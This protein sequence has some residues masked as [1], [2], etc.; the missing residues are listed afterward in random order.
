MKIKDTFKPVIPYIKKSIPKLAIGLFALIIVDLIQLWLP[1]IMQKMIDN[2]SLENFEKSDITK[3]SLI[4]IGLTLIM[5]IMRFFWRTTIIGNAWSLERNIRKDLHNHLMKLSKNYF[6]HSKTGDLT[7]HATS[8]LLAVRMLFGMGFIAGADLLI[9]SILSLTFMVE[10]N[11]RL[12]LLSIIPLPLLTIVILFLGKQV[13]KKASAT[14]QSFSAMSGFVQE[15]ISG[16]RVVKAFLQEDT[17][18]EQL[19]KF[20]KDFL[21]KSLGLVKINALFHPMM[22]MIIGFSVAATLALGGIEAMKG[23]ISTGELMAFFAYLGMLA[24]PMIAVGW[25]I[26]LYQQAVASLNRLNKIFNTKAEIDDDLAD[27][28]LIK[29]EGKIEIKNL[30]FAYEGTQKNILENINTFAE[31]GKTLAII[32]KTGCGKSTVIDLITRTYNPPKKSIFIDGADIY[33]FPL[34]TLR[35]NISVIPQDIFLFSDSILENI[36]L[37]KPNSNKD[38]IIEVAKKAD[39]H[40]DIIGFENG[41]ETIIGE[42]GVTL[43]GGQKQRIAIARALLVKPAILILDDALSAIDTKTE[44]KII[45]HLIEDRKGKTT[46]IIAHRISSLRHAEK[47]IVIEDSKIHESGNHENLIKKKGLYASIFEKQQITKQIELQ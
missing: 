1:K 30:T 5:M 21:N 26:N 10:I 13:H 8:D 18:T 42:R 37:G 14:Q 9:I 40:N 28:S 4:M 11:L 19:E 33:T 22:S 46:I 35:N 12:T 2:I 6:N 38:E 45:G 23:E 17:E 27:S 20:G 47:I 7:A 3:S 25:I 16:I 24:W 43:S 34:Q 39:V 41:Y 29:I 44:E 36:R 32:G 31:K 15:N